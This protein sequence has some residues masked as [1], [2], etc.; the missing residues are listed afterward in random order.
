MIRQMFFAAGATALLVLPPFNPATAA[1]MALK[2]SPPAPAITSWSGCYLGGNGGGLW[3][4]DDWTNETPGAFLG[5]PLSSANLNGGFGGVQ[6]GCNY[7]FAGNWLIGFGGDYDWADATGSSPSLISP[8]TDQTH[9]SALA[10]VTGRIGYS[11]GNFLGYVKGGGAWQRDNYSV[12]TP[13][14]ATA[15]TAALS[16]TGWTIGIGGEYAF[17]SW[18]SGFVEYDHYDFGTVDNT[19]LRPTGA[20]FGFSNIRESDEVIKAGLNLRWSLGSNLPFVQH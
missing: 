8:N 12:F 10:S 2:A 6:G 17:T 1:D 5:A 16:P 3:V 4:H 14:G 15:A 11:W 18:L 7:Q 19:F 20:V 9:I 13:T